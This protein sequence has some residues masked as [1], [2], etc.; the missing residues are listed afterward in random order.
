MKLQTEYITDY[1]V[2]KVFE[3]EVG[4]EVIKVQKWVYENDYDVEADWE[5]IENKEAY[6]NLSETKQIEFDD[7]VSELSLNSLNKE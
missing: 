7:F 5:V 4:N 1:R 3:I 6:D 2:C